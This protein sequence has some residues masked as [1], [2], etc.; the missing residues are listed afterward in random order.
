MQCRVFI[1]QFVD[2]WGIVLSLCAHLKMREILRCSLAHDWY[3][4]GHMIYK[5][6][7]LC[8]YFKECS[9]H[10]VSA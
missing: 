8:T 3:F 1:N 10:G 4:M 5:T 2:A 9:A 6:A 7:N